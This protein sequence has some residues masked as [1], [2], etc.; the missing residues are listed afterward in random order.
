MKFLSLKSKKAQIFQNI[1]NSIR[2]GLWKPD[3]D[4]ISA[5]KFVFYHS[6]LWTFNLLSV[7]LWLG[8]SYT[9][10]HSNSNI[11]VGEK[12]YIQG[13]WDLFDMFSSTF[14]AVSELPWTS[15]NVQWNIDF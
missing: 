6:P 15:S 10:I 2:L 4:L 1:R 13:V 11:E 8:F 14:Q 5:T 9:E 12:Q 7:K 3:L